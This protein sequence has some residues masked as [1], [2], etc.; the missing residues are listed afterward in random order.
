MTA[1]EVLDLSTRIARG[2]ARR[3][4]LRW[5][6]EEYES[7]AN[8]AAAEV[9]AIA[10]RRG[11]AC[12]EALVQQVTHRRCVDVLQDTFGGRPGRT[13]RRPMSLQFEPYYLDILTARPPP[14]LDPDPADYD[15]LVVC[16]T[17]RE[18]RVMACR[19]V[20][21][22]TFPEIAAAWGL[23]ADRVTRIY[24]EGIKELRAYHGR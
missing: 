16:L 1:H 24:M 13:W 8:L 4:R 5:L 21:G 15:A 3:H 12:T 14:P 23:S 11:M 10:A 6:L 18:R 9:L 22:Q 17:E 19:F 7:A 2:K 20:H